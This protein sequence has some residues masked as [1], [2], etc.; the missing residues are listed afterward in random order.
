MPS[1]RERLN[2]KN[3]GYVIEWR[4]L[5]KQRPEI[6]SGPFEKELF[7][8]P[9]RRLISF[10]EK[11]MLDGR[12]KGNWPKEGDRDCTDDCEWLCVEEK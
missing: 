1:E 12:L 3:T 11:V 6:P 4:Q 2:N 9:R 8:E 7:S 5:Y 10:G